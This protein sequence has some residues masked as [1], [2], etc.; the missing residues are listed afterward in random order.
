M[1]AFEDMRRA[2]AQSR[3][4]WV[5]CSLCGTQMHKAYLAAHLRDK[6]GAPEPLV[7][8]KRLTHPDV[9]ESTIELERRTR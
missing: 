3:R 1:S 5:R 9:E 6:C 7:D 4:E 8:P 2:V